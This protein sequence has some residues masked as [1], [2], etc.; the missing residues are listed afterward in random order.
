[1]T[2]PLAIETQALTK[3][4]PGVRAI[5]GLDLA[6]PTG[7]ICALIGRNGAGKTTAMRTLFGMIRPTSGRATVLGLPVEDRHAAVAIRRRAAFVDPAALY[8]WMTVRELLRLARTCNADWDRAREAAGLAVLDLP[9]ARRVSALSRGMRVKLALLIAL[10]RNAELFLFDEPTEGLDPVV[11]RQVLHALVAANAT[12]GATLL[13]S[14]HQLA[15][16]EEIANWLCLMDRGRLVLAGDMDDIRA[17]HH[18]V[19][20]AWPAQ[21]P[22]T[23]A[24]AS[25]VVSARINGAFATLI[26]AGD[27]HM[28]LS[29]LGATI[30]DIRPATLAE[31][32]LAHVG[33]EHDEAEWVSTGAADALA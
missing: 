21:C 4:Y 20:A 27:A 3:Q 15:E 28:A 26:V 30:Q 5:D 31:I 14:S 33:R 9:L 23:L 16:L 29:G 1:V 18:R 17:T 2:T 12:R 32:V 11:R 22:A 6:V 24:A 19:D 10:A 8:P 25:G 13:V 7:A